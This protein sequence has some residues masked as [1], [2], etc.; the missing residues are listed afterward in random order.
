VTGI[1]GLASA[2]IV[3]IFA[4]VV[5]LIGANTSSHGDDAGRQSPPSASTVAPKVGQS[6]GKPS[7]SHRKAQDKTPS[8]SPGPVKPGTQTVAPTSPGKPSVTGSPR[9][10]RLPDLSVTAAVIGSCVTKIALSEIVDFCL[11]AS[12][13]LQLTVTADGHPVAGNCQANW[14]VQE[15][16]QSLFQN[17]SPAP[18]S[19]NFPTGLQLGIGGSYEVTVTVTAD[20]G[21]QTTKEFTINV[22][23]SIENLLDNPLGEIL[24]DLQPHSG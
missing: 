9:T 2:I 6:P 4:L 24:G 23:S 16:G 7:T 14:T 1:F 18:C 21:A 20:G 15:A 10:T 5:A 22:V 17:P 13:T 12:L 8:P 19:G 11:P 3:G